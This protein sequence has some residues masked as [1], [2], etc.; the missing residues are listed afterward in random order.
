MTLQILRYL[1]SSLSGSASDDSAARCAEL[2]GKR[3]TSF[4]RAAFRILRE[5]FSIRPCL[6]TTQILQE[7]FAERKVLLLLEVLQ[8]CRESHNEATR[9]IRQRSRSD[10]SWGHSATSVSHMARPR[11]LMQ[12]TE[13]SSQPAGQHE[14]DPLRHVGLGKSRCSIVDAKGL[15]GRDS[16]RVLSQVQIHLAEMAREMAST[17]AELLGAHVTSCNWIKGLEQRLKRLEKHHGT[18]FSANSSAVD[19]SYSDPEEAA[20]QCLTENGKPGFCLSTI[21]G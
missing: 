18:T 16:W 15:T 1:M 21:R 17:K 2:K 6:N 7:G 19:A 11:P 12:S 8:R 9:Q 13:A 5:K 10:S 14:H 3:E 4:L 20:I